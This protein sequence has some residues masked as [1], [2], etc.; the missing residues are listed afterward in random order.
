MTGDGLYE[1]GTAATF[2]PGVALVKGAALMSAAGAT[3]A[4]LDQAGA[5]RPPPIKS[6]GDVS[7]ASAR[8]VGLTALYDA[9]N[10]EAD[11]QSFCDPRRPCAVW[12]QNQS[13]IG[14]LPWSPISSPRP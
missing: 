2:M 3:Q 5:D 11:S 6:D 14:A 12:H 8:R 13:A 1:R 10:A 7:A 9:R 4:G